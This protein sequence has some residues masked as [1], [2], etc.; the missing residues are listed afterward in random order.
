MDTLD[1]GIPRDADRAVEKAPASR[2]PPTEALNILRPA[3]ESPVEAADKLTQATHAGLNLYVNGQKVHAGFLPHVLVVGMCQ[4]DGEWTARVTGT[5]K[6]GGIGPSDQCEFEID[7]VKALLPQPDAKAEAVQVAAASAARAA[8]AAA[9]SAA[10]A[11]AA[12]AEAE[13]ARAEVERT[14]TEA[15]AATERLEKAEARLKTAEARIEASGATT[16]PDRAPEYRR[17]PGPKFKDDWP[18]LVAA[19]MIRLARHDPETLENVDGLI[20]YM[21]QHLTR[22]LG[23]HGPNDDKEM[24]T[25]IRL[26]L[27]IG[28]R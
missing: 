12:R 5:V 22:E 24:R 10:Q 9:A 14:R 11:K 20:E 28:R 1:S 13:Q 4:P 7:Q 18:L 17:K 16:S 3:F 25:R 23:W 2:C 6:I 21:R 26:L 15:Q 19:E 27:G 8:E